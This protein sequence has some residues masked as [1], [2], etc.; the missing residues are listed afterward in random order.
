MSAVRG[1]GESE[2]SDVHV[3]GD[4]DVSDFETIIE[5]GRSE[6]AEVLKLSKAGRIALSVRRPPFPIVEDDSMYENLDYLKWLRRKKKAPTSRG[7]LIT[8]CVPDKSVTYRYP[9]P[10]WSILEK[11][12]ELFTEGK[13]VLYGKLQIGPD[14]Q[15]D[16]VYLAPFNDT[17]P[18]Y[19][20]IG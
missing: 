15:K 14:A 19:T 1:D 18:C 5:N 8:G 16:I 12:L 4:S 6:V 17:I 2:G 10:Y 3:F 7:I 11:S 9:F 20:I 13:E